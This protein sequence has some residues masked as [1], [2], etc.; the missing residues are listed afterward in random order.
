M[1]AVQTS[2][3]EEIGKETADV[4]ILLM[5]VLEQHGLELSDEVTKKM[6]ENRARSWQPKG[7][8]TGSHVKSA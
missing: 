8:G 3:I 6:A 2:E 4:V 5:R 1:E 7:D